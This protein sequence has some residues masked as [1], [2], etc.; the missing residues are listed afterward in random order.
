[1]NVT[2]TYEN[3]GGEGSR[4]HNLIMI[5]SPTSFFCTACRTRIKF[6]SNRRWSPIIN[7]TPAALQALI[8][9][10]VSVNSVAIGFSQNTCLLLAAQALI[11]SA[12]N[13]LGLQIQ[14]A[15]TTFGIYK[16]ETN[17]IYC[18]MIWSGYWTQQTK[19]ECRTF[20]I[21]ND[22]HS[23]IGKSWN[24]VLLGGRLGFGY[25]RIGYHHWRDTGG[26]GNRF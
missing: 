2:F 13:E 22:F 19:I 15:S 4:E 14:T 16:C 20:W 26:L 12:W 10:T 6:W 25:R 21:S 1:M 23:V 7:L 3:G 11:C 24:I 9:S 18:F 17:V 8:A 5:G